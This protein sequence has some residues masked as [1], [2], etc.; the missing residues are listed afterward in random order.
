MYLHCGVANCPGRAI[1]AHEHGDIPVITRDH[2]HHDAV[3]DAAC[4]ASCRFRQR[5]R[6]RAGS[7]LTTLRTIYLEE[8]EHDR[9]DKCIYHFV[10]LKMTE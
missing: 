4:I 7:E 5:I 2:G 9:E 10:T 6:D 8:Q 1:V 3:E